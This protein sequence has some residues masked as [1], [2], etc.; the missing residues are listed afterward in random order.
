MYDPLG[1]DAPIILPAKSLLQILCKQKNGW[2]EE[3]SDTDSI[4]GQEWLKELACLRTISVQATRI[5]CRR[6][7]SVTWFLRCFWIWLWGGIV[8]SNCRRQG[9]SAL[10]VC[11]WQVSRIPLRVVSIPPLEL[12][13]AVVAVKLN[14]LIRNIS[15]DML[16]P[17]LTRP[18]S[19]PEGRKVLNYTRWSCDFTVQSFCRRTRNIGL[20]NRPS[21][22]NCLKITVNAEN[23]LVEQTWSSAVKFWNA[24]VPLFIL[25]PSSKGHSLVSTF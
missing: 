25:G 13:A 17:V 20:T 7:C 10:F 5:R 19:H 6:Q 3:I 2:D 8:P 23:A 1:F 12:A 16:T 18:T 21:C 15:G 24:V 22:R 14:C 4:V 9:C 11:S